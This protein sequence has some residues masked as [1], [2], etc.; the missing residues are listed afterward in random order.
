M[1]T[2]TNPYQQ[3]SEPVEISQRD[4]KKSVQAQELVDSFTFLAKHIHKS[5]RIW[6]DKWKNVSILIPFFY[7]IVLYKWKKK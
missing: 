5:K 2:L 6:K 3:S 1:S 4:W 7:F